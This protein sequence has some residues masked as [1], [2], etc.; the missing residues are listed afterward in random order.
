MTAS[1]TVSPTVSLRSP[2]SPTR[3]RP[4]IPATLVRARQEL[5]ASARVAAVAFPE[6]LLG[7]WWGR[8]GDGLIS[9]EELRCL[10]RAGASNDD[11]RALLG[12]GLVS[13]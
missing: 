3:T 6:E 13:T 8:E 5:V 9:A 4:G 7:Q 2:C 11:I 12:R 1:P 10:V